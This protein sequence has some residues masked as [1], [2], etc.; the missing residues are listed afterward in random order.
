MLS[1]LTVIYFYRLKNPLLNRILTIFLGQLQK[2]KIDFYNSAIYTNLN[3]IKLY[4][5]VYIIYIIKLLLYRYWFKGS[6]KIKISL[7]GLYQNFPIK[8][9]LDS[10]LYI[11]HIHN[12]LYICY[13]ILHMSS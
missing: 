7:R 6:C 2:C 13:V 3:I 5:Y 10:P 1:D 11:M 12:A 9:T 8:G 4:I